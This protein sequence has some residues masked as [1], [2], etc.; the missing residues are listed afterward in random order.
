[1]AAFSIPRDTQRFPLPGG[2]TFGAK[3]NGLY[4]HL[5]ARTGRGA[6]DMKAA[7]SAAFDLEVDNY[8]LIGFAGVQQL[9]RAVGGVD[10]TLARPYYD[11]YYW[12][13]NRTQGWGLPAGKSH[14]GPADALI[15]ARSRK[16][17]N[18]FERARRQQ[19]LVMAALEKVRKRGLDDVPKL[20]RIAAETVRTD[21]PVKRGAEL[22]ELFATADLDTAKRAV[23][24]PR[25]YAES[26]GGSAFRLRL[27][28]CK[29]WIAKNFPPIRPFGTW[30]ASG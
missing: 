19:I 18:D 28:T 13:N 7:V 24:G 11:P 3:V 6:S 23:F 4:Q 15:F 22:F 12:V 10:V 25:T 1:V 26:I 16:G 17:D 20:L 21:L 14:L 29:A 2:G 5:Q 27:D 30:P 8:V 9:V